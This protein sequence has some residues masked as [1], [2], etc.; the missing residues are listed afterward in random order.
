MHWSKGI[1]QL[2]IVKIGWKV[3]S[4]IRR[5]ILELRKKKNKG[6]RTEMQFSH[7]VINSKWSKTNKIRDFI[8][9]AI[10]KTRREGRVERGKTILDYCWNAVIDSDSIVLQLISLCNSLTGKTTSERNAEEFSLKVS[11]KLFIRTMKA[12]WVLMQRRFF[13]PWISFRNQIIMKV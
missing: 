1:Q 8:S 11:F 9:L 13:S 12:I 5:H 4:L 6:A 7:R 2:I 10:K 3:N